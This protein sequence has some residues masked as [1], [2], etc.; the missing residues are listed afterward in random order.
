MAAEPTYV[1]YIGEQG[2]ET[3]KDALNE[4][5]KTEEKTVINLAAGTFEIGYCLSGAS[6]S[7]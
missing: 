4:A 2:Y 5:A 3:L 6:Q 1:A 7:G